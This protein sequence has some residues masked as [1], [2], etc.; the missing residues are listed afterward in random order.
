M[1][2]VLSTLF[3]TYNIGSDGFR[4][5]VGQVENTEDIKNSGRVQV[6]IVGVHH[7]EGLVT[8]TKD[9][10]W[11]NVML[12]AN[13]PYTNGASRG[14]SNLVVGTWVIGFY[15][16]AEGQNPLII[17]SV[18]HTQASTYKE[19]GEILPGFTSLGLKVVKDP[20]ILPTINRTKDE[21]DGKN[22]KGAIT[23]AGSTAS[24]KSSKNRNSCPASLDAL[25]QSHS[26]INPTGGKVCVKVADPN[27]DAKDLGT[28]IK[29]IIGEL[30]KVN[31]QS[32]GKV[33]SYYVGKANGLLYSGVN[34]PRNYIYKINRLVTSFSLRVK[35]EIIYGIREAVEALVKL[36]MG[37]QSAKEAAEKSTDA[38]KNPKESYVPNTERGNFLKEVI[39][40]FNKVLGEL[41]CAFKKTLDDLIKFI[42]DLIMQYII[43]AF[44]A[45][46]CL[47]DNIIAQILKFLETS[48]STL[49]SETIGPLQKLLGKSG[50][51]LDVVGGVINRVFTLLGISCTGVE[52][53]CNSSEGDC[54]D[55]GDNDEKPKADDGDFL[56]KLIKEIETGSIT[57]KK[58]GPVSRGVCVDA[59]KSPS[60]QPTSVSFVGGVL[61]NP[62]KSDYVATTTNTPSIPLST[63]NTL[64]DISTAPV[65]TSNYS[66]KIQEIRSEQS[67]YVDYIVTAKFEKI[68]VG[69][70]A[71]F[72]IVGPERNSVL[73][74]EY[75][76]SSGEPLAVYDECE[77]VTA[78][79]LGTGFI[80]SL[81]RDQTGKPIVGI[82]AGGVGYK[83][84]ESFTISGEKV[85]G[86][87]GSDDIT[88]TITLV[89]EEL[90]YKVFGDV[91][92]KALLDKT[93]YPEFGV[94]TYTEPTTLSFQISDNTGAPMPSYIGLELIQKRAADSTVIWRED[95]EDTYRQQPQDL[96]LVEIN[97]Q[98]NIYREGE[99]IVFN[100]EV[101]EGYP[102][103]K[104]F[105]YEFFGT[106]NVDDYEIYSNTN[107]NQ[108]TI[109]N[110][111]AS[112]T[113]LTN[114][115]FIQEDPENLTLLLID[116]DT[117]VASKN[118]V[119]VDADL[120]TLPDEEEEQF[121]LSNNTTNEEFQNYLNSLNL[122]TQTDY[123]TVDL[124]LDPDLGGLPPVDDLEED[125]VIVPPVAGTPIVDPDGSI[126]SIPIINSGNKSYQV[127][128]KI[129]I[130]G[131]G[132]GASGIVLLD[133]KGF[134]SEI[135]VTRIGT[136]Y[137]GILPEEEDL[138]CIIDSFTIIRPGF[139][140]TENSVL[141]IDGDPNIAEI[142]VDENGFIIG[143]NVLNRSK[144]FTTIP[145]ITIT[146]GDGGFVLPNLVCLSPI[147][148]EKKGVAKIGTGSY[149]D[150]P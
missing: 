108:V 38:P 91:Y 110:G 33:G 86:E 130:T 87:D 46:F 71:V 80:V 105:S 94:F 34:I 7:R 137:E 6:R 84:G 27:C 54:S 35:Q 114:N 142:L 26:K 117:S 125:E 62:P 147:E 119:I 18:A 5:F 140:Y 139:N 32:G 107:L 112:I 21:V 28:G 81:S 128:P 47:I 63:P 101:I 104:V 9:L 51:F 132:Y 149:I 102:E 48:F 23:D 106:V 10:P 123:G 116:D 73:D 82:A 42:I 36:I 60:P 150:C 25:K 98:K 69:E 122:T 97:T 143:V 15:L 1:D 134:V 50:S 131:E 90:D 129:A 72:E 88:V 24:A 52:E 13:V 144:I 79:G 75:S 135:R 4:W 44:S 146:G 78:D 127:A 59:R 39:A 17:G 19:L 41:G 83:S 95:P 85:G 65:A 11:V 74:I 43:D 121:E 3:P 124:E 40:T 126:I 120:G 14:A 113:V 93:I 64:T 12:P 68:K 2:P 53:K 57:G 45:A 77:L 70:T 148:L 55:G 145:D 49:I 133:D 100:I 67:T 103:G 111:T 8:P 92:D 136:G 118:V 66:G 37:V 22:E 31:Q 141:Y 115:D 61:N 138:S 58:L 29:T 30:L 99:N 96:K 20:N 89:G 76:G 109:S 16:D 56:D